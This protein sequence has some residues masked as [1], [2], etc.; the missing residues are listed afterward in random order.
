MKG[1]KIRMETLAEFMHRTE[2]ERSRIYFRR[3]ARYAA[4]RFFVYL[5]GRIFWAAVRWAWF[6]LDRVFP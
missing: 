5:P 6:I 2:M 4:A 3:R 1:S